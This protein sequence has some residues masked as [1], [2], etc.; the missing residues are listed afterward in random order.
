MLIKC[1]RNM[2]CYCH[3]TMPRYVRTQTTL[4]ILPIYCHFGFV[5]VIAACAHK[6]LRLNVAEDYEYL[7]GN[8][9]YDDAFFIEDTS[10]MGLSRGRVEVC[11]NNTLSWGVVCDDNW[12][13]ADAS[14]VCRQ[15]G[16][17][18]YGRITVVL[19]EF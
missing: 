10:G 19:A 2:P 14:V 6:E 17:S 16:F 8:T 13:N 9:Q 5:C 3:S 12:T 1:N 7:A 15:L 11:R 18:P 4:S